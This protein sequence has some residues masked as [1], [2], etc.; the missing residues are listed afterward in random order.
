MSDYDLKLDEGSYLVYVEE[1][2]ELFIAYDEVTIHYCLK[3][4]IV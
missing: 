1:T 3:Q 2:G 4:I